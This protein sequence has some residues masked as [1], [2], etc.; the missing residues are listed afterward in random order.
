M[1]LYWREAAC[2]DEL[3]PLLGSL[4]GLQLTMMNAASLDGIDFDQ[5]TSGL[6]NK[7]LMSL[8]L[9]GCSFTNEEDFSFISRLSHLTFLS[10]NTTPVSDKT[11][12]AI[13][14]G[15]T[16]LVD[17]DLSH[18]HGLSAQGLMH[19]SRL[20]QLA[21]FECSGLDS[22]VCDEGLV[23]TLSSMSRLRTFILWGSQTK[24]SVG[25]GSP[26]ACALSLLTSLHRLDLHNNHSLQD[27][28]L[29]GLGS[30]SAHLRYLELGN[31]SQ[32]TPKGLARIAELNKLMFLDV[33][34][35][36]LDGEALKMIVGACH[37]L[38]TLNVASCATLASPNFTEITGLSCLLELNLAHTRV[39]YSDIKNILNAC[40]M[41]YRLNVRGCIKLNKQVDLEAEHNI[42]SLFPDPQLSTEELEMLRESYAKVD[43]NL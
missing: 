33:R 30:L 16:R 3:R 42:I 31:C 32:L 35:T 6:M 9:G 18:C 23:R 20:S 8:D 26:A 15:C 1:S 13:T 14:Q 37:D 21:I 5:L 28:H 41:L 2:F 39:K 11:I 24:T 43:F 29:I 4:I 19:L 22:S 25:L 27:Q 36:A 38:T 17:L 34:N 12:D 10:L 40:A 7:N